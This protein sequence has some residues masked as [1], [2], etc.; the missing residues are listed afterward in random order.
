M[1]TSCAT[2]RIQSTP[3]WGRAERAGAVERPVGAPHAAADDVAALAGAS[4]VPL[5]LPSG[6]AYRCHCLCDA[7]VSTSS[8]STPPLQDDS[9]LYIFDGTFADASRGSATM[10]ADYVVPPLFSEDLFHLAGEKRRPP[11]K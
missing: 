8:A 2:S 9:P 3:R 6:L 7:G 4:R 1:S 11:Y 5:A 10:A